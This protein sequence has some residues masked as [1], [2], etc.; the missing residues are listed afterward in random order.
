[1]M[2]FY[3]LF[4]AVLLVAPSVVGEPVQFCPPG[5]GGLCYSIAVP[6]ASADAGSGNIYFQISAPTSLQWVGL[7]TGSGMTDSSIFLMYQDGQGNVTLSPRLGTGHSEPKLDTS[8]TAAKLTLLAGSGVSE[9]GSSMTANVACSNCQS[10]TGGE[11]S[12]KSTSAGWIS[13]WKQGSSLA[14][15]DKGTSISYH[16]DRAQFNVDLTKAT[17][18]ADTN[19][20]VQASGD[21]T[22][23]GSG[24]GSGSDGGGSG[25]GGSGSGA[26]GGGGITQAIPKKPVILVAHGIIM[27]LVFALPTLSAR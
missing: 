13:A 25:S 4:S 27:A 12:L 16:D 24:P 14:T 5:V 7:G 8:S 15:T 23:S 19:P 6:S 9:D 21:G 10:W 17:I 18:S 2:G 11:M 26:G 1:M 3:A 22:G 20:F